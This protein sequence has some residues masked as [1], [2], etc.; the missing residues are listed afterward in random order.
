LGID[1]IGA[2]IEVVSKMS[3]EDFLQ[4]NILVPLVMNDTWCNLPVSKGNRLTTVYTED[5]LHHLIPPGKSD[6]NGDPNYPL[7][8]K[9]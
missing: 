4:K 3:L 2:V 7:V 6:F 8:A 9:H 5:S 1:V